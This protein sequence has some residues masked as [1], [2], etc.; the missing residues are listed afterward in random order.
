[1]QIRRKKERILVALIC[2][3]AGIAIA[4]ATALLHT[5]LL[6]QSIACLSESVRLCR[7]PN[8][9]DRLSYITVGNGSASNR[10]ASFPHRLQD[11]NRLHLRS[12]TASAAG[13]LHAS[14]SILLFR[15]TSTAQSETLPPADILPLSFAQTQP[16]GPATSARVQRAARKQGSLAFLA[17]TRS[18]P[19]TPRPPRAVFRSRLD[20]E[21][22]KRVISVDADSKD[23]RDS[24]QCKWGWCVSWPALEPG[25]SNAAWRSPTVAAKK[26]PD[27]GDGQCELRLLRAA[28]VPAYPRT[29]ARS[30]TEPTRWQLLL[31]SFNLVLA[32]RADRGPPA[33]QTPLLMSR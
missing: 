6:H 24:R 20:R 27:D 26:G 2:C 13:Q 32:L 23:Q 15:N 21:L 11:S 22:P 8:N 18:R 19:C 3:R 9:S 33:Q 1:V 30:S 10:G 5:S 16:S 17:A 31:P 28:R 14:S 25:Q 29:H 12:R 4:V 7:V